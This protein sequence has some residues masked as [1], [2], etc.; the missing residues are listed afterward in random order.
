MEV[1]KRTEAI[2][3]VVA[4]VEGCSS[5]DIDRKLLY[6]D[7]LLSVFVCSLRSSASRAPVILYER[8]IW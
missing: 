6:I 2:T 4:P 5:E 8:K 7:P 3:G 1:A